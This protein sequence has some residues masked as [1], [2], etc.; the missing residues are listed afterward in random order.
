MIAVIDY[1]MGNLRSVLNAFEALGEDVVGTD[2]PASLRQ[3]D[4]IVLPGVGAFGDGMANLERLGF[5]PVLEEEILRK[6]KPFLGIC[7]GLQLLAT[8]GL[9]HGDYQGLNWI[10][11]VVD[12][13]PIP[14]KEP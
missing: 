9:E 7:L 10:S 11:G 2:D 1:G 12:R 6:R 14:A 5:V 3:A 4:A 13:L 8:R